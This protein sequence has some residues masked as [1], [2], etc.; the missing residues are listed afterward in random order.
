VLRPTRGNAATA[1]EA[2]FVDNNTYDDGELRALPG[3]TVSGG[4]TCTLGSQTC[5]DGS[6]GFTVATATPRRPRAARG[7]AAAR[8]ASEV[9][10]SS[11]SAVVIT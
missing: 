1:N 5:A 8:R 2:A 11:T 7:T 9:A 6:A 3:M 4:V 10:Q